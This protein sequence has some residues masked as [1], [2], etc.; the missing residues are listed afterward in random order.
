MYSVFLV[1]D[2]GMDLFVIKHIIS[3]PDI[4]DLKNIDFVSVG[5]FMKS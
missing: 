3:A 5:K 2:I 4:L 1:W